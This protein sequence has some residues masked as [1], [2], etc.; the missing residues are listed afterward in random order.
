M[1]YIVYATRATSLDLSRN[2]LEGIRCVRDLMMAVAGGPFGLMLLRFDSAILRRSSPDPGVAATFDE[3][4]ILGLEVSQHLVIVIAEPIFD[5]LVADH[6]DDDRR[7]DQE[8]I[9]HPID[10]A[11]V[12]PKG[13][14]L[15]ILQ[16]AGSFGAGALGGYTEHIDNEK[17]TMPKIG[18]FRGILS[19]NHS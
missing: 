17:W 4:A 2:R 18:E 16:P 10:D 14:R 11:G 5:H 6:I 1:I 8:L 9:A 19:R 12:F 7:L 13:F 15:F 3:V